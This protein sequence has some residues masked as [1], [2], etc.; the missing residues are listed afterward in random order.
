MMK[1]YA[2]NIICTNNRRRMK[3]IGCRSNLQKRLMLQALLLTSRPRWL[4]IVVLVF[5]KWK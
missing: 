3:E 5:E 2:I 4:Q 1:K